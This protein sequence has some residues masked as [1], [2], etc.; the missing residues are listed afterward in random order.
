MKESIKTTLA[1]VTVSSLL[2][3]GISSF[4]NAADIVC[5]KVKSSNKTGYPASNDAK[6][7]ASYLGVKKCSGSFISAV[8]AMGESIKYVPATSELLAQLEQEKV[9]RMKERLSGFSF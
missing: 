3:L 9:N 2:I 7:L 4:A 5:M 8:N 6:K 1:F